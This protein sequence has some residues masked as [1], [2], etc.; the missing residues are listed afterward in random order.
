V[1]NDIDTGLANNDVAR[2]IFTRADLTRARATFEHP[3]ALGSALAMTLP[4]ALHLATSARSGSRRLASLAGVALIVAAI[5]VTLSRG[6]YIAALLGLLALFA[7]SGATA[8]RVRIASLVAAG[9]TLALLFGGELLARISATF[10]VDASINDRLVDYPRVWAIFVERPIL[11]R[12][13]GSLNPLSFDYVD[14]YFLKTVGEL[15]ALGTIA[16]VGLF[17]LVLVTLGRH[18]LQLPVG[19]ARNLA[20]AFF[21]AAVV[22]AFQ[23]A[24]FDSFSFSKPSGL[25][26]I[27]TAAG[28]SAVV[29][30]KAPPLGEKQ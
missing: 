10:T 21:A 29:E 27:V 6:A 7:C 25:F 23:T 8:L 4:L 5:V 12:G 1:L 16:L 3:I 20:A 18:A 9:T 15:G 22:F 13:L 26:W 14:N 17:A 30:A 24:T 2:R 19:T 11:G 28:M